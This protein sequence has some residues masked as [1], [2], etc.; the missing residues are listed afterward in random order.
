MLPTRRV[1][2]ALPC[3]QCAAPEVCIKAVAV[4]IIGVITAINA[5]SAHTAARLQE[6]LT[7]L[8]TVRKQL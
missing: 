1:H 3:A 6:V 7:A 8:K 2:S 5:V 4:C